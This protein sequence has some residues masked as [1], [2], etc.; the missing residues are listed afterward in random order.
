[1][2]WQDL[3]FQGLITVSL[4]AMIK[5]TADG[6]IRENW[7]MLLTVVVAFAVVYLAVAES[8]VVLDYIRQSIY[9]GLGAAGSYKLAS[10]V[11][12]N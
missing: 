11:G 10:K 7:S 6:K 3:I 5:L 1:M 2:N 8:F 9:V 4:V 12:G